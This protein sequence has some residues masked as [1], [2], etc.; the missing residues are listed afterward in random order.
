VFSKI[1]KAIWYVS[2]AFVA[3]GFVLVNFEK[4]IPLRKELD[5]DFGMVEKKADGDQPVSQA[6][7]VVENKR[8]EENQAAASEV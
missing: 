8:P 4:E 3:L 5:T 6:E 7:G 1:L 2:I